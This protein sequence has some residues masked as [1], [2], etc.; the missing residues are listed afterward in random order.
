MAAKKIK[1]G[2]YFIGRT[3]GI[4]HN[5]QAIYKVVSRRKTKKGN[6]MYTIYSQEHASFHFKWRNEWKESTLR[7]NIRAK[8]MIPATKTQVSKMLLKRGNAPQDD[9][10]V[11]RAR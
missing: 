7:A 11:W 9:N 1:A 8:E 3:Y 6:V 2:D 10:D 5:Q 4:A